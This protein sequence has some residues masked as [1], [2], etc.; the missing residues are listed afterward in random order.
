MASFSRS[1]FLFFFSNLTVS[2]ESILAY[3]LFPSGIGNHGV[4]LRM[5]VKK[6]YILSTAEIRM[7][8]IVDLVSVVTAK[9]L[10]TA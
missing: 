2:G 5:I 7:K 6:V 8:G 3:F 9:K 1:Y 4:G 10:V